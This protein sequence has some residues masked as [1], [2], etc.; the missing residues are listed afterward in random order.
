MMGAGGQGVPWNFEP[1]PMKLQ[2]MNGYVVTTKHIIRL[3]SN[4]A[5]LFEKATQRE[6]VAHISKS[7]ST[8]VS[9]IKHLGLIHQEIVQD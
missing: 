5:K 4:Q 7:M 8:W 9:I 2:D 3:G 1:C 6:K